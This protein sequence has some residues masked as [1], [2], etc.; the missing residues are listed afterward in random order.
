MTEYALGLCGLDFFYLFAAYLKAKC[1]M[2]ET[3]SLW[4]KYISW[5]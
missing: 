1:L 2:F 4:V 3:Y 5:L